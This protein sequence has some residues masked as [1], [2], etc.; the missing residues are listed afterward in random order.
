LALAGGALLGLAARGCGS[1][2][3]LALA[4]GALLRLAARGCGSRLRLALAGGALFSARRLADGALS[5]AA[6]AEGPQ[7]SLLVDARR[8]SLDVDPC[9]LQLVEDLLGREPTLL[10]NLM[11]AFVHVPRS[12][13]RSVGAT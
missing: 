2:L 3:R 8:G 5:A 10:G 11:D 13:R 6:V 12:V 4:G 1:R 9:C 7:G